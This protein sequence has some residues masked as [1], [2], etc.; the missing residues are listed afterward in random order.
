[1]TWNSLDLESQTIVSQHVEAENPTPVF[2]KEQ[3]VLLAAELS[4]QLLV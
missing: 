1:M 4:L 2:C 3:N